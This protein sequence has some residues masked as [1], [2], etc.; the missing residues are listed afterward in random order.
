MVEKRP[1]RGRSAAA[2]RGVCDHDPVSE[3][4]R[5]VRRG[6][7]R[8]FVLSG[9]AAIAA[10]LL[11]AVLAAFIAPALDDPPTLSVP[12]DELTPGE[13]YWY[14]PFDMGR[15]PFGRPYGV[16]LVRTP[17]GDVSALLARDTHPGGYPGGPGRPCAVEVVELEDTRVPQTLPPGVT[18]TPAARPDG[19]HLRELEPGPGF[20]G[21]CTSS[22]FLA[23][24]TRIF[25][26]APRS[27]DRLPTEV[28]D[29]TVRIDFSRIA[30]GVC[31]PGITFS[32]GN[33]PYS[34]PEHIQYEPATWPG[35]R[36]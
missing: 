35:W 8:L 11:A 4:T 24:G 18:P 29:G 32:S 22:R 20:R 3:T 31:G 14:R 27:L 7:R 19:S 25:G 23:D 10:L 28:V 30:I 17:G 26:P 12:V 9:A 5:G 16:F 1:R 33:C 34:T 15:D 21:L 13:P 6:R 2:H 36:G